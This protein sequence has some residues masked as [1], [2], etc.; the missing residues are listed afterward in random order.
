M[1]VIGM[2]TASE[3]EKRQFVDPGYNTEEVHPLSSISSFI[4]ENAAKGKKSETGKTL[5]G[6][7]GQNKPKDV[8]KKETNLLDFEE[9]SLV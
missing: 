1:N 2:G 8:P 3:E 4:H 9:S 5:V 7:G 6:P